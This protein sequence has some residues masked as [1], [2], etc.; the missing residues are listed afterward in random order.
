V[1]VT[2][3][4]TN[5]SFRPLRRATPWFLAALLVVTVG[6]PS[7]AALGAFPSAPTVGYAR[8]LSTPQVVRVNL[9]DAPAFSPH[10]LNVPAGTSLSI[11]L[12]NV[13]QFN[14]TFTL[15]ATPNVQLSPS[16]SPLGVYQFFQKYGTLA[17]VSLVPGGQSWAN[18]TFNASA[19]V[20]SFEFASVIPYQFQAGM[21]GYLNVTSVGP[22]LV[23]SENTTDQL[24]FIPNTL[25]ASPPHYP[26]VV[27]VQVTNQ[28]SFGHTFTVVPQ[29][30]VT[31]SASNFTQYFAAHPALVSATVPSG[32]GSSVWANFTISGPG[33]YQY[34]CQVPGHFANGMSG[35]LYV[36]VSVPMPPAPPSTALVESWVLAGSAVLLAI[37][38]TLV[39]VASF[40]GRFR[41]SPGAGSHGGPH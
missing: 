20:S 9:T 18:V 32:A 36:G 31:L 19:G 10:F 3:T 7:V 29:S 12:D 6:L 8:A 33:V 1:D 5:R 35:L 11:L 38:L 13:G 22:G 23:L 26:V 34:I 39:A 16:V 17:N 4:R 21:F 28:G 15:A 41:R 37:G 27:D 25:S 14:H 24:Q 2:D 30:N 40:T